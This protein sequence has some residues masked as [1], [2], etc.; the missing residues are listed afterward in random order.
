[1]VASGILFTGSIRPKIG[2]V[3]GIGIVLM[4]LADVLSFEYPNGDD[5]SLS[6][7]FPVV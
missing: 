2:S 5:P 4:D 3:L 1:M 6:N 7:S